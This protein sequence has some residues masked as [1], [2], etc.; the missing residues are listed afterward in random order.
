M[1]SLL[2]LFSWSITDI[3]GVLLLAVLALGF[4]YYGY[5]DDYRRNQKSFVR[6]IIGVPLGMFFSLFGAH[7]LV[8]RLKRWIQK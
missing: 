7:S 6:T 5:R 1:N 2:A 8:A 4:V 3:A